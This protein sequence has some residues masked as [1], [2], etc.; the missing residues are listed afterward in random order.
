[1]AALACASGQPGESS[2]ESTET[3][4][5]AQGKLGNEAM[6]NVK[7][8]IFCDAW[9]AAAFGGPAVQDDD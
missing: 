2:P 5:L 7:L 1:M 6:F 8:Y 4:S 3:G 9:P